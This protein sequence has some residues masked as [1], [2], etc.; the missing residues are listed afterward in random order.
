MMF[1]P[2]LKLMATRLCRITGLEEIRLRRDKPVIIFAKGKEYYINQEGETVGESEKAYRITGQDLEMILSLLCRQ[3]IY[4]Y[5]E[6]IKRG[7]IT[8]KG[9]HRVGIAGQTIIENGR[10]KHIRYLSGMNVRIAN[11]FPGISL[12]MLPFL[13]YDKEP[14][15][16]L[17]I[18]PPGCGKTTLLRDLIYQIS[19]GNPWGEGK[20]VGVVDERS[21]I[22]GGNMGVGC[23]DLGNRTDVMD[24]C[25]KSEG[26]MLMIRS[27]NPRVLAVDELGGEED[28]QA[29]R[30][31]LYCGCV[32]LATIHG[33]NL[34]DVLR[35]KIILEVQKEQAFQ[36]FIVLSK[37]N[38]RFCTRVYDPWQKLLWEKK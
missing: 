25:P 24:R 33:A 7:F 4:A 34:S 35:K 30:Q 19:N 15:S 2:A 31:A 5:E 32:I 38:G 23:H 11:S 29:L 27:M 14:L 17:L 10:V 1:P 22:Q 16:T 37:Q 18:S 21:E 26:M 6:E 36:R 12:P 20:N 9:G 8:M 28:L 3:S 13:Y